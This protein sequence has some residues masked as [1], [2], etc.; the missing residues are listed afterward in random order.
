MACLLIQSR[1]NPEDQAIGFDQ[2]GAII[3]VSAPESFVGGFVAPRM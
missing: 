1:S 3:R 2:N